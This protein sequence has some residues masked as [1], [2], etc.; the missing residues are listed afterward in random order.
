[1]IKGIK[2]ICFRK[3]QQIL[4]I[5]KVYHR[6]SSESVRLSVFV[7]IYKTDVKWSSPILTLPLAAR[8]SELSLIT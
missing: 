6:K 3:M 4:E 1:M 7:G 8:I 5:H 2:N